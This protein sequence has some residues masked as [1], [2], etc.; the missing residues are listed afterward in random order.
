MTRQ[1]PTA[2]IVVLAAASIVIAVFSGVRASAQPGIALRDP[3]LAIARDS[4]APRDWRFSDI[5]EAVTL[6]VPWYGSSDE[7]PADAWRT[8]VV[9]QRDTGSFTG[10]SVPAAEPP[11]LQLRYNPAQSAV[12]MLTTFVPRV[13]GR[14]PVQGNEDERALGAIRVEGVPLGSPRHHCAVLTFNPATDQLSLHV[15]SQ[16]AESVRSASL[17][18]PVAALPRM[19]SRGRIFLG[20]PFVGGVSHTDPIF[21]VV[22]RRGLVTLP[23]LQSIWN[24]PGGP[25]L[26][27]LI[28]QGSRI[29]DDVIVLM[30]HAGSP[31]YEGPA[32]TGRIRAWFSGD[33]RIWP[34]VVAPKSIDA[35]RNGVPTDELDPIEPTPVFE[36]GMPWSGWWQT[37]TPPDELLLNLEPVVGTLPRLAAVLRRSR[38]GDLALTAWG[39]GNSRWANTTPTP[40]SISDPTGLSRSHLLGLRSARPDRDGGLVVLNLAAV[41]S[42]EGIDLIESG[43]V[44]IDRRTNWTRF[45]YG[46][47][48]AP[49]PGTGAPA[50]VAP[51]TPVL[52]TSSLGAGLAADPQPD[53]TQSFA[54]LLE[55]PRGGTVSIDFAV[56]DTDGTT[57]IVAEDP[58]VTPLP[59]T[60]AGGVISTDT[61]RDVLTVTDVTPT[62]LTVAGD[63]SAV[64]PGDVM[65]GED[66]SVVN[67]V[68]AVEGQVV[69]MRFPWAEGQPAAGETAAFGPAGYRLVGFVSSDAAAATPRRGLRLSHTAGG[70]VTVAGIGLRSLDPNRICYVLAGRGG[71]G[72]QEQADREASGTLAA[73]A[74]VLGV[75]LFF[76]GLATQSAGTIGALSDQLGDRLLTHEFI[77]TPDVMNAQSNTVGSQTSL[78]TH[79]EIRDAA[80]EFDSWAYVQIQDDFPDMLDQYMSLWRHDAPHPNGRAMLVAGDM[81]WSRVEALFGVLLTNNNCLADVNRDGALSP[82]DFNAWILAYNSENPA[83]EQNGDGVIAPNDFNAW[84]LNFNAGCD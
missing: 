23:E 65:V 6:V 76:A 32:E 60:P 82:N 28:G 83:A 21:P 8:L 46:G 52:F 71:L 30:N 63:A 53:P 2:P 73:L 48:F 31:G 61:T 24:R 67:V 57:R 69:E 49:S 22:F 62:T 20:N 51:G 77:G 68:Q 18:R 58:H 38:Q 36:P 81:W 50:H 41:E 13:L 55:R 39:L 5:D 10:D 70:R 80:I 56:G 59:S 42:I 4:F 26:I 72:Q 78:A 66:D 47:S 45:S 75:E 44:E 19:T 15:A 11:L 33:T 14:V 29:G 16:G 79:T 34:I 37:A 64:Q 3:S 9:A 1:R 43:D 17:F 25:L 74:D 12:E 35:R 84:L 54:V 27:E 7:L 40:A